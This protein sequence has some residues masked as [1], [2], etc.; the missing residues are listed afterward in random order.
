MG[1]EVR[2]SLRTEILFLTKIAKKITALVGSALL[3]ALQLLTALT[4][5]PSTASKLPAGRI[6]LPAYRRP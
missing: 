1:I 2:L 5:V 3:W 6:K 4:R